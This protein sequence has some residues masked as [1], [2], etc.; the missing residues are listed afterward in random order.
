MAAA[1]AQRRRLRL[2]GKWVEVSW[3]VARQNQIDGQAKR[4]VD[5]QQLA[6]AAE[7][8]CGQ[9]GGFARARPAMMTVSG[10]FMLGVVVMFAGLGGL[11][12]PNCRIQRA[13]M[14][15]Q[16]GEQAKPDAHCRKPFACHRHVL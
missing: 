8:E 4:R 1:A 7:F 16:H 15:H 6:V 14:D 2:L 3:R 10:G 12:G 11:S 9:P 13:D 5:R